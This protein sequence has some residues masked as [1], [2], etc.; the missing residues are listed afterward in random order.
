MGPKQVP[1]IINPTQKF[2]IPV[3]NNLYEIIYTLTIT[4]QNKGKSNV[5]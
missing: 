2:P 1:E 5:K 3:I 4:N